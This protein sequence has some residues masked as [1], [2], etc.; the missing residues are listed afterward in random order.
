MKNL[1][2]SETPPPQDRESDENSGEDNVCAEEFT[3]ENVS[4]AAKILYPLQDD[5]ASSHTSTSNTET[6]S[7]SATPTAAGT[8]SSG[9]R[10]KGRRSTK[11]KT[12]KP[13]KPL[14]KFS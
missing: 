1:R 12:P 2:L 14:Y 13:V 9:K 3:I 8:S 7:R 6:T 11:S 10:R 4:N 5:D